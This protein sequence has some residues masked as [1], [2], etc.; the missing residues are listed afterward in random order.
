MTLIQTGK[1]R[2]IPVILVHEPFWR[3]L[4]DWFR[5]RLVSE[6]MIRPEDLDLIQVIDEPE[7]IVAAIF[8]HYESRGFLPLPEEHELMLNL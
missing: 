6:K 5:D 3:G 4:I 2:P 1:S 7:Q 8:K